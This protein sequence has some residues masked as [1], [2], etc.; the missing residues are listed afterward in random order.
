MYNIVLKIGLDVEGNNSVVI[1]NGS[2]L[3]SAYDIEDIEAGTNKKPEIRQKPRKMSTFILDSVQYCKIGD[4]YCV[5]SAE[6]ELSTIG[7]NKYYKSRS[8]SNAI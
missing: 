8:K 4:A 6:G 5:V 3:S 7:R 1:E 2:I